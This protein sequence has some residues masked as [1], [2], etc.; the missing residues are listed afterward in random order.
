MRFFEI[1]VSFFFD[2]MKFKTKARHGRRIG[3]KILTGGGQLEQY[4]EFLVRRETLELIRAYHGI[5]K[6]NI[7]KHSSELTK[8]LVNSLNP[9]KKQKSVKLLDGPPKN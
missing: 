9:S 2:D 8:S 4:S 1:L 7:P 5:E 3:I 6:S